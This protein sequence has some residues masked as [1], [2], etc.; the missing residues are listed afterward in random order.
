MK[1]KKVEIQAFR[2]YQDKVNGTFDFMVADDDGVAVPASFISLYAP[3]GFG[4]SSF[5][6][7]VE[8]AMTNGSERFSDGIFEAAAR[9]SKRDDEALR[10]LRNI[11]AP[12]DLETKVE[13]ITTLRDFIRTPGII[14]KTSIDV[15]FKDKKLDDGAEA[16][17]KI[18]LSQDAI[19]Y[20][21][22]GIN[23]EERYRA[24]IDFYG[25][26][27]EKQR[28]GLQAAYLDVG[29]KIDKCQTVEKQLSAEIEEPVDSRLVQ[30]FLEV[31]HELKGYELR[32]T[33][34][35]DPL[36]A[37]NLDDFKEEL[38]TAT[39]KIQ[40][41]LESL[42]SRELALNELS[43]GLVTFSH[44]ATELTGELQKESSLLK[45]ISKIATKDALLKETMEYKEKIKLLLNAISRNESVQLSR[46][47]YL[48]FHNKKQAISQQYDIDIIQIKKL[49]L[50]GQQLSDQKKELRLLLEDLYNRKSTLDLLKS[51][52]SDIYKNI[53]AMT[54]KMAT[55]KE[56]LG[57]AT[58]ES[59][60]LSSRMK[61]Q[62]IL[63]SGISKIPKNLEQLTLNDL[64]LLDITTDS[65]NAL[66]AARS[67]VAC[68]QEKI[69][70]LNTV[71]NDLGSQSSA[72]AKLAA[73]AEEVLATHPGPHCPL[74]Q[75]DHGTLQ[76][77]KDAIDSNSKLKGVLKEKSDQRSLEKANL[78]KA[79][80]FLSS[81]VTELT[82]SIRTFTDNLQRER[83]VTAQNLNQFNSEKTLLEA[84]IKTLQNDITSE[85]LI[86][87]NLEPEELQVKVNTDLHKISA[88]INSFLTKMTALE[89]QEQVHLAD[90]KYMDSRVSDFNNKLIDINS[91]QDYLAVH[92]YLQEYKCDLSFKEQELFDIKIRFEQE[93][94]TLQS[95]SL[96]ADST[97][98]EIIAEL[99][100]A[101]LPSDSYVA[102]GQ[103]NISVNR[104]KELR[105]RTDAFNSRFITLLGISTADFR[106][107][108][109]RLQAAIEDTLVQKLNVNL[110]AEKL[111]EMHSLLEF[112]VPVIGKEI[113]RKKLTSVTERRRAYESLKEKIGGELELV[114]TILDRQLDNMFQTDL[115]NE[116]YRKIDPHPN[117]SQIRFACGFGL[118]NKP[119]LNVIVRDRD[120]EKEI[121]PLLYFSAAQLN[122]LSLSI[123]LA[124]ALN[125]KSPE[126]RPL[127]LILIDDP[128]HSMD[129][130][131]VLSTIDL[132][133][134][135]ALNHNKQII[136]STHDENFY[137]LLKRKIPAGLCQSKFL[138]LRSL[139]QVVVDN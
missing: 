120:T 97:V 107:Y 31:T 24:F 109:K 62:D 90:K 16:Y 19:D 40:F 108:E 130:I 56:Q 52:A 116:I 118:K 124:R 119:T 131:N 93:I 55:L 66:V 13:V 95:L 135:I 69:D 9:G 127:D 11:E 134:G 126:G 106:D 111:S 80:N 35:Q 64:A 2:A 32:F 92:N 26:D 65:L 100:G 85:K 5:Y 79:Q 99:K 60:L 3:N 83:N 51:G 102:E 36:H 89:K 114:N 42:S 27:T 38:A 133:R 128:I 84:Q 18:F 29:A 10:I 139:G 15:D 49:N 22:R 129:S 50:K 45:S 76:A 96:S 70:S 72:F 6:D 28:S 25:E 43:E 4:K 125:A 30:R 115:I 77:L 137:E 44:D 12:V 110:C 78:V 121:S 94:K 117:F 101:N 57:H 54:K 8:W 104:I 73:I 48:S 123:F 63:L 113:I 91:D 88:E 14:R 58:A 46:K 34:L 105:G 33:T 1:I 132:L 112:V 74:C 67:E 122:I 41:K 136:I 103:L 37:T 71:I 82:E 86:V 53:M 75:K 17:R 20:F 7:A 61:D 87:L 81:K 47:K 68:I 59:V 39:A 138:K 21:I 23:P 98:K